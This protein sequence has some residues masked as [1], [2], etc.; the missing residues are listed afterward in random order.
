MLKIILNNLLRLILLLSGGILHVPLSW[1]VITCEAI[2]GSLRVYTIPLAPVIISA[3]VDMPNGTI[4]YQGSWLPEARSS[5]GNMKCKSTV[6]P[7][8]AYYSYKTGIKDAPLPLSSWAGSPY[9]GKVY[10]TEIPGVGIALLNY[11]HDAV[12]VDNPYITPFDYKSDITVNGGT[13]ITMYT[14]MDYNIALIKIGNLTPGN[15]KLN[16]SSL[17]S[18]KVYYDKPSN[19]E[20]IMGF[21]IT[22]FTGQF[23]GNMII[24]APTCTTPDVNV[25]LGR[26]DISKKL[27]PW[28]DSSITLT[29]CPIFHGYYHKGNS[30]M[31]FDGSKNGESIIPASTN[32]SIGVKLTPATSIID[33]TNGI[34]ALK[35]GDNAASGVGIQLG[36]GTSSSPV[37]FNFAEEK[38]M[39]LPKD[40]SSTIRVPLVA[41]YIQTSPTVTPGRA[42]ATATFTINYK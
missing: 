19:G 11:K 7:A 23:Q 26:H 25:Y 1:A 14:E 39:K 8:T 9:S 37:L 22:I 18:I 24:T 40:G 2:P 4:L 29:N 12:T 17:P 16:A 36:W 32:N 30:V 33:S 15:Y 5:E 20:P 38:L 21:P 27:T 42:D 41:R 3:G 31:M 13:I 34:M 28:V 6:I 10:R 35:T